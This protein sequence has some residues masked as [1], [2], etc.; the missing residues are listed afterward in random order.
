MGYG[1]Y[2]TDCWFSVVGEVNGGTCP[3]TCTVTTQVANVGSEA[4]GLCLLQFH[5]RTML[6]CSE[7]SQHRSHVR[8]G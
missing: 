3:S 5:H 2:P 7:G 8:L 6:W 4:M 1:I